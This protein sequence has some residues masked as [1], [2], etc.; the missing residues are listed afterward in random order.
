MQQPPQT[1]EPALQD[2]HRSLDALALQMRAPV[3]KPLPWAVV[4]AMGLA[5]AVLVTLW[6]A[7]VAQIVS[8]SV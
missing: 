2:L 3:V 8:W 4:P 6:L 5:A 1:A 7:G